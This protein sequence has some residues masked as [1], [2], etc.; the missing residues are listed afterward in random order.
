MNCEF[1]NRKGEDCGKTANKIGTSGKWNGRRLC[2]THF[3]NTKPKS[4]C[5]KVILIGIM[6]GGTRCSGGSLCAPFDQ[7]IQPEVRC[8][9]P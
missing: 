3:T 7:C 5:I 8:M 2:N 6:A 1:V 9:A 4:K